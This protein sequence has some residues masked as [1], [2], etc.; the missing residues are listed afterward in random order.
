MILCTLY[1]LLLHISQRKFIS[2]GMCKIQ[3]MTT[4]SLLVLA[5]DLYIFNKR[6]RWLLEAVWSW[7]CLSLL[8]GDARA[9]REATSSWQFVTPQAAHLWSLTGVWQVYSELKAAHFSSAC[10]AFHFSSPS[11]H[12][13]P[14]G[15]K[16][17][18]TCHSHGVP[19]LCLWESVS[20]TRV[21]HGNWKMDSTCFQSF[22]VKTKGVW[23]V[24]LHE[25]IW[26]H[27][28]I[29]SWI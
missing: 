26:A 2:D 6:L 13:S 7:E 8:P 15:R 5:L 25:N 21:S 18:Q 3:V 29:D 9:G 1:Q 4:A 10:T 19:E 16:S 23:I 11:L 14:W 28:I 22:F 24:L 27:L 20:S 12:S 17:A